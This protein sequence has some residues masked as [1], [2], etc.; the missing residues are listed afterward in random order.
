M[1]LE[2]RVCIILQSHLSMTYRSKV[3]VNAAVLE[4]ILKRN[5]MPTLMMV[6]IKVCKNM[7]D[8]NNR[9]DATVARQTHK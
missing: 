2:A 7:R 9:M 6:G 1:N 8:F 4:N 5:F 3:K